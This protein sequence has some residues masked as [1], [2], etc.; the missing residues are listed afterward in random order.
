M[1]CICI[2]ELPAQ[3]RQYSCQKHGSRAWPHSAV[4]RRPGSTRI[5]VSTYGSEYES[6]KYPLCVGPG[7]AFVGNGVTFVR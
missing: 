1:A 7:L 4:L 6:G 3:A 5:Y 2:A